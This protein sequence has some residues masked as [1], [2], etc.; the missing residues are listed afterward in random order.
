MDFFPHA[1]VVWQTQIPKQLYG[2]VCSCPG[3]GSVLPSSPLAKQCQQGW[4]QGWIFTVPVRTLILLHPVG[5]R[6]TNTCL[7]IVPGRW[8]SCRQSLGLWL[9]ALL[10]GDAIWL[11]LHQD[12]SCSCKAHTAA[13]G[14]FTQPFKSD[15][16]ITMSVSWKWVMW[17]IYPL[18]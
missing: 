1:V 9:T 4:P 6:C 7:Q 14:H 10:P 16:A 8:G 13:A 2:L 17:T 18:Y 5:V 3:L 12:L 15:R 11:S